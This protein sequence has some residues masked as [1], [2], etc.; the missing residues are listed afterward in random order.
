MGA[1]F[2]REREREREREKER[3]RERE[4]LK[5]KVERQKRTYIESR[6]TFSYYT[7]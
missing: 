2:E 1:F 3:K 6:C 7:F 4:A 5:G